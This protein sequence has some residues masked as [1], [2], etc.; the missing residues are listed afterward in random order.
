MTYTSSKVIE[1][2]SAAFR[3]PEADS[4]CKYIHGY[5]LKAELTF[6]CKE[7]D[8]NNWVFDFGGLKDLK[9]IFNNQFDHTTVISAKDPKLNLFKTLQEEDIIQLRIMDNGV[10]I[11]KFAEWC[12]KTADTFVD[13]VTEG[14]VW[15]ENVTVYE[16]KNNSASVSKQLQKSTLFVDDEGSKTY[17]EVEDK[18]STET[19]QVEKQSE[20]SDTNPRAARVGP[21][22]KEGNFSDPFAGTT[23]GNS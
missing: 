14:R 15:V 11:E 21:N 17:V 23:W 9:A 10:G 1:L 20:T 16:H 19:E 4:H 22:V 5:Q 8:K 6:G 2:G 12:F 13:E 18:Q 3:Q 7:L